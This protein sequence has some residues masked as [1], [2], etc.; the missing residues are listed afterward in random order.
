[1]TE[2]RYGG[3]TPAET[4]AWQRAIVAFAPS[5][6]RR[7]DGR[8]LAVDGWIG[9]DDARV[10]ADYRARRKLPA[11]PRGVVVTHEEYAALVKSAP[12]PARKKHLGIVFRGTGGI[13]GQDY[14]SRV[15]QGA[16]DLIEERNPDFPAS[17]GGLPPGAPG[18][19]SAQ[20]AIQLGVVSGRREIQTGRTFILG[21]YSLGAIVAAMLRAEL[22]PGGPLADYRRNY[23]CGFTFGNPSRPFGHT[24]YLGAVPSGRGISDFQLP[25][26]CATWDWCDLVH[27]DDMY[28]N[29]PLGKSGEIMTGAYGLVTNLQMNDMLGTVR[30]MLPFILEIVQD[31]GIDLPFITKVGGGVMSAGSIAGLAPVLLPLLIGM[32]PGLI[33]GIGAPNNTL[34]GPAAAV[35]AAIIAMKFLI[36][37]TAPHIN[38]HAWEVWPGQTYLGLAIQHVRD[39]AT[40]V[41]AR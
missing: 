36:A 2:L 11:P 30:A 16:G 39:W 15:C 37:G 25:Q 24:Y 8:P 41:P 17:M 34:T 19:P 35:Q 21:G 20:K 10:A 32:L 5:Y 23:V 31:A 29:V 18:T 1:M 7:P 4:M 12:P 27:P 28:A 40:R 38:Y 33:G 13:I 3:A 26:S 9:D 14:V 22:E 6:A